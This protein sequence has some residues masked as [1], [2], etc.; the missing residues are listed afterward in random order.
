VIWDNLHSSWI[1]LF[2]LGKSS[3]DFKTICLMRITSFSQFMV[4][5]PYCKITKALILGWIM[6]EFLGMI[7]GFGI[8]THGAWLLL[9][10][11]WDGARWTKPKLTVP[12]LGPFT[13][14]G[15]ATLFL[16]NVDVMSIARRVFI[17]LYIFPSIRSPLMLE[18]YRLIVYVIQVFRMRISWFWRPLGH[19]YSRIFMFSMLLK[20][21]IPCK[22]FHAYTK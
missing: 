9:Q 17:H 20:S 11:T 3:H 4:F 14:E 12:T 21:S 6:G 5:L 13:W 16:S 19:E 10:S 22:G 1:L 15:K 18:C 7:L 2:Y 8:G